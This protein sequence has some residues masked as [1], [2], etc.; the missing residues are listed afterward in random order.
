[1]NIFRIKIKST[2]FVCFLYIILALFVSCGPQERYNRL[3]QKH[4]WLIQRD[5]VTV[6]DTIIKEKKVIVPEYKDSF[7]LTHDTI[8]ETEKIII[9]RYKDVTHVT[10]KQDTIK[11]VDTAYVE[12]KVPGKIIHTKEINW[13]YI[14]LS[15]VGG[16]IAVLLISRKL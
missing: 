5:T 8:I 15:F 1:M 14:L 2:L 4:P 13:L 7:I 3:T 6:H 11:F 16:I 12:I 9:Q 10:V